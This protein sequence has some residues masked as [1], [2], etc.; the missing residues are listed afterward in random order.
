MFG[1]VEVYVYLIWLILV[2][3]FVLGM[4]L[5]L[6]ELVLIVV[7]NVC[8]LLDYGFISVYFVGVFSKKFEISLNEYLIIGGLLGLCFIFFFVECELFNDLELDLG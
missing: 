3:K 4:Y 5:L 2:E 7:C 6:E 8:I 1:L